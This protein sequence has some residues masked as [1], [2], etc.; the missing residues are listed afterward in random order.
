MSLGKE[1]VKPKVEDREV[2]EEIS[3]YQECLN[4]IPKPILDRYR[5][6]IPGMD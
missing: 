6:V 5:C 1:E 2:E 4:K 3:P